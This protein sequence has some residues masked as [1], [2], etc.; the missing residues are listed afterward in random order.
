MY[1]WWLLEE[2][3]VKFNKFGL[4]SIIFLGTILGRVVVPSSKIVIN[5]PMTYEKLP[6]KGKPYQFSGKNRQ[7]DIHPVNLL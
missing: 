4:G 6:C 5:L 3:E 7:A 1:Y 2:G